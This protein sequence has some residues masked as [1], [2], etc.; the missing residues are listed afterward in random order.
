MQIHFPSTLPDRTRGNMNVLL[1]WYHVS[2][3][4]TIISKGNYNSIISIICM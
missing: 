2:D 4:D 3:R 1:L